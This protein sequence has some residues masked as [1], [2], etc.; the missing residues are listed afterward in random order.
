[1]S[2][3]YKILMVYIGFVAAIVGMVYVAMQQ[4]N[5]MQDDHYYQREQA[6]QSLMDGKEKLQSLPE[7]LTISNQKEGVTI[8]FPISA[9]SE[10]EEAEIFFLKPSDQKL[11]KKYKFQPDTKG[12]QIIPSNELVNGLYTVRIQWKNKG[13]FYYHEDHFMVEK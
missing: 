8:Q 12:Q 9:I 2:W 10:P 4:T 1:M 7:A 6:Y 3:G 5:D 13:E 11:D